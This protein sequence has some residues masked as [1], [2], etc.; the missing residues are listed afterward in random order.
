MYRYAFCF[1]F[2][3]VFLNLNAIPVWSQT[4]QCIGHHSGCQKWYSQTVLDFDFDNRTIKNKTATDLNLILRYRDTPFYGGM[5]EIEGQKVDHVKDLN[6][7]IEVRVQAGKTVKM[8][9]LIYD[10]GFG[11][12]T[13]TLD[14]ISW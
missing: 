3:I 6:Y 2:I 13:A 12:S 7:T 10:N 11:R 1:A 8:P 9:A 4:S 14:K 5:Y